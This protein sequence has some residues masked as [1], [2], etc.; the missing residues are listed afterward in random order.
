MIEQDVM[1]L[2]TFVPPDLSGEIHDAMVLHG[3]GG[4]LVEPER[5]HISLFGFGPPSDAVVDRIDRAME[6]TKPGSRPFA[7]IFEQLVIGA[8]QS[9]L[10]PAHGET[11]EGLDRYSDDCLAAFAAQG[12]HL[13]K[14]SSSKPHVTLSYKGGV[15]GGTKPLD[16][17]SWRVQDVTLIISHRPHHRYTFVRRWPLD[18]ESDGRSCQ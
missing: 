3:L 7:V 13:T 15:D 12:L 14:G 1:F 11:L 5:R 2:C 4:R 6:M 17:I 16:P 9:L 18:A 8:R 10:L